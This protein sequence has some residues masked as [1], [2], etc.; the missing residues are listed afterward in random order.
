MIAI[1]RRSKLLP[2]ERRVASLGER[3]LRG[4]RE[5]NVGVETY[6]ARR[7]AG[8]E[9]KCLQPQ[10]IARGLSAAAR[11]DPNTC[12]AVKINRSQSRPNHGKSC[13]GGRLNPAFNCGI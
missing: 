4:G 11:V 1:R 12:S 10:M 5:R 3:G 2:A 9:E 13:P 8:G 7:G 6:W